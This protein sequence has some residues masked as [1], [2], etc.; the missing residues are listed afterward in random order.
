MNK[1]EQMEVKS[2]M[3]VLLKNIQRPHRAAMQPPFVQATFIRERRV[4][5]ESNKMRRMQTG[6]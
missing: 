3:F 2:H 5:T 6:L 1:N 4:Q